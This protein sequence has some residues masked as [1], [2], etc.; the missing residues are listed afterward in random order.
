MFFLD[1]EI[2]N[3]KICLIVTNCGSNMLKAVHNLNMSHVACFGHAL[4][5]SI[6]RIFN[7][8]EIKEVIHK[9]KLI[10]NI[11]ARS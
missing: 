7:K 5:A 10:H 8:K 3:W 2:P 6:L 4:N 1:Y 11:F 9:D